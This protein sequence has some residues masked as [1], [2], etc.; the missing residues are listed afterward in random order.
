MTTWK[1]IVLIGFSFGAGLAVVS[2]V[3]VG[4]F[5]WY[6]SRPNPPATWNTEPIKA[7]FDRVTTDGSDNH[8]SF[9]Y[10]LENTTDYDY[11]LN[12]FSNHVLMARLKR[13][14]GLSQVGDAVKVDYPIYIP[15]KQRLSIHV[16]LLGPY[17]YPKRL[18]R[19]ASREERE[20]HNQEVAKYVNENMGNLDGFVLFDKEHHYQ[21]DLPKGW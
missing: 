5:L 2:A 16:N 12:E 8:F 4:G 10:V 9:S 13:Q 7:S 19:N 20:K 21:I 1:R 14:K 11:E 3:I 15:A 18:R 6:N 17:T